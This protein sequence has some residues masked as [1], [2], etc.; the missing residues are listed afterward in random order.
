M[1]IAPLAQAH[2][3]V[4]RSPDAVRIA[5]YSPGIA[6]LPGGR[7]VVT[8]DWGCSERDV[9]EFEGVACYRSSR[10]RSWQGRV[11]TSDDGG[12]SWQLRH[13]FPFMHARPFVAGGRL[14]VLGQADDLFVIASDDG[15]E[16]WTAPA[17]LS[18]GQHWHQAPSNVHVGNG[19]VYLVMERRTGLDIR[20]WPIGEIAPVTMRAPLEADLCDPTSWTFASELSFRDLPPGGPDGRP[21]DLVGL[22]FFDSPYPRG[23][24]H[25]PGRNSAPPGWLESHVVQ[26]SDPDHLWH[27]P[28][29][30]TLHLWMRSHAGFPNY[31]CIARVVE[32]GDEPGSGAM[33]TELVQA[34]SGVDMLY[35]PCPGGHNKFH[36]CWDEPS[37]R[38]WLVSN[39]GTDSMTRPEALSQDRY[40]L[41]YNQRDRLMLHFSRN[42]VDWCFAGMVA[43]GEHDRA[44]RH[45][46]GMAVCG[47]D[48][49]VVSRSGDDEAPNAHDVN[50]ITFHRV[51]GFRDLVY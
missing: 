39:Q 48:L 13:Y 34:P 4:C 30:R 25:G 43:I 16:T 28:S 44:S 18:E 22:P 9:P 36:V 31:A 8:S 41:P 23:G 6:V 29:G 50:L 17:A 7:L 46:A 10:D 42:M 15:G 49:L 33:R 1:P 21:V 45:Y 35:V 24:D 32:D 5:C 40:G 3:T 20:T 26:F 2:V 12:A 47:D 11:Y 38:Y 51:R 37:Q 19:C 14:Y 27:D